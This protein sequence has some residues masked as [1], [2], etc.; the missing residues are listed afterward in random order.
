MEAVVGG[1]PVTANAGDTLWIP[2]DTVH[3]FT[4]TSPVCR[5]LNGYEPA[6]V[7]QMLMRLGQPA[8]RRELPPPGAIPDAKTLTQV[9]NN[10]WSAEAG[11]GWEH[12]I[13]DQRGDER[14]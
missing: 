8:E 7:E 4:V 11:A 2:R 5:V 13:E 10:Y 14:E 1:Q 6:G 9:F 3:S 12:G